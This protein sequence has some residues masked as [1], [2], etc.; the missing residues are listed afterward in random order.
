VEVLLNDG[1]PQE[2]ELYGKSLAITEAR[3]P[4]LMSGDWWDRHAWQ[5]EIWE[6]AASDGALYQLAHEK[7]GW[8]L[9]GIFC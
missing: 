7:H 2:L 4:W 1:T 6:V 5:R 3:G 8:V 9:D